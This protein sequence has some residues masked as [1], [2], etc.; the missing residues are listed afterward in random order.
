VPVEM[1]A[2]T[3]SKVYYLH[4]SRLVSYWGRV[5][6]VIASTMNWQIIQ[7]KADMRKSGNGITENRAQA[8]LKNRER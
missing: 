1:Y 6:K 3:R 7:A 8:T 5:A 2:T 4:H